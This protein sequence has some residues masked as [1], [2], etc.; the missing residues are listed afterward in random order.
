L[1]ALPFL[2]NW[3]FS[4]VYSNRLDWAMRQGYIG[5]TAARKISTAI[6]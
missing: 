2:S 4:I 1:S 3:L 5:T 6:S